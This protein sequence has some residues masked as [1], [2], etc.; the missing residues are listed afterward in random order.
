MPECKKCSANI[1]EKVANYSKAHFDGRIYKYQQKELSK[2]SRIKRA[3][4]VADPVD[5][6]KSKGIRDKPRVERLVPYSYHRVVVEN[7]E[8]CKAKRVQ[9]ACSC[10]EENSGTE[11]NMIMNVK[12]AMQLTFITQKQKQKQSLTYGIIKELNSKSTVTTIREIYEK[13]Q[14]RGFKIGYRAVAARIEKLENIGIVTTR[15]QSAGRYGRR[16]IIIINNKDD[17]KL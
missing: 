7:I 14:S 13:F 1:T 11:A 6:R 16:K 3:A 5:R 2:K 8:S 15:M 12:K 17:N 9:G 4:R 10:R